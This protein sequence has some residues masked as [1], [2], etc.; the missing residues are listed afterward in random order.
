LSYL[1][2]S[3]TQLLQVSIVLALHASDDY[4]VSSRLDF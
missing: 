3:T 1:S 2:G 4:D